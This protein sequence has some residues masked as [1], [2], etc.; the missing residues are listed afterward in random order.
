Y[1]VVEQDIDDLKAVFATVRSKDRIKARVRTGGTIASLKVDEGV[2]VKPGQVLAVIADPKIALKIKALEAKIIGAESRLK[3]ASLDY[4]R[5]KRLRK[6]NVITQARLDQ[7]KTAFDVATNNLKAV[8][9]DRDVAEKQIEEGQVLAP[10]SGRVLQVPVTEGSVVLMGESVATI[11]ANGYLLRLALPE[12]HARFMKKGAKIKV[13]AR[14]LSPDNGVI[15][16]GSIIQVYPEVQG[17]RVIAD[18]EVPGLGTYFVGERTLVWIPAGKRKTIVI[19]QSY[20][21]QRFGLDYVRVAMENA[22]PIDVVVQLGRPATLEDK[23]PAVEVLT[24]LKAGDRL[25]QP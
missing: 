21:F 19:P 13:G 22:N 3:T 7:L 20:V 12:R 18:A 23:T 6:Q 1:Q 24:G 15:G 2:E 14:G 8:Q 16:E 17:G 4:T 10:A 5:A 9:A 25:V 11:A